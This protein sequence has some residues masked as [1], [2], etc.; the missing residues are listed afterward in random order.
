MATA[1]LKEDPSVSASCAPLMVLQQEV[2]KA[3]FAKREEEAEYKTTVKDHVTKAKETLHKIAKKYNVKTSDVKRTKTTKYL[4]IGE[5]VKVTI[6]EKTGSKVTFTKLDKATVGEEVYI[7][8]ETLHLE[9]ETLLINI[10]QGEEDVLVKKDEIVTVQQDDKDISLIKVKVGNYCNEKEVTNKDEFIDK[11]IVKIKLKPKAEAKQKEW[12]DGLK[13]VGGAKALLYLLVDAHS[14]NSI[15]N[16]KSEYVLYKGYKGGKDDSNAPNHF[17]NEDGAWFELS[18]LK[19]HNPIKNPQRL[20]YNSNGTYSP[21]S[22]SFGYVRKV[23]KDGKLTKKAHAG[24]DIFAPV[25]ET[26]YA[27]LDGEVVSAKFRGSKTKNTGYGNTIIIKVQKE[28][29]EMARNS[30]SLEYKKEGEKEKGPSFGDGKD[31]YLLYAHLDSMSVKVG[32][33]VKSG[34]IIGKSGKTGNANTIESASNRH[35]HFEVLD[36]NDTS[37]YYQM[38]NRENAAFYINFVT[39]N[40]TTQKNN[41]D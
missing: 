38:K 12:E 16:F 15:K 5:V 39:A 14:E 4:Q 37:S 21:K 7:V 2:T 36:A 24:V 27:S 1:Y 32:D 41:K 11:A 6:K 26:V 13:C 28:A 30:Y 23:Y 8:V 20:L 34:D 31:R 3:Y 29:L 18:T 25:G 9:E 35:L 19:W 33:K 10:L 17:L 40:K 22:G